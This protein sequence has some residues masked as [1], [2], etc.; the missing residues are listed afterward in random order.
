MP[1]LKT[2]IESLK[3]KTAFSLLKKM[4]EE[5]RLKNSNDYAIQASIEYYLGTCAKFIKEENE[6][7]HFE[8]AYCLMKQSGRVLPEVLEGKIYVCCK[9]NNVQAAQEFANE[10]KTFDS[11]DF[12]G[13]IPDLYLADNLSDACNHLPDFV[14]KKVAV[15][16]LI[17][18]GGGRSQ[19][20]GVDID[21]YTIEKK[22]C[23]TMNNFPVWILDLSVSLTRY[24]Q[25]P[26]KVTSVYQMYTPVA[27]ELFELTDLY[28]C[29]LS[30]NAEITNMLPDTAFIHALMGY[31]KDQD[32][33]WL[34]ILAGEKPTQNAK[35]LY[36][37]GYALALTSA[38]KEEEATNLL[39]GYGEGESASVLAARL[40]TAVAS[41]NIEEY[42]VVF[43]IADEKQYTIPNHL[44]NLFL[45]VSRVVYKDIIDSARKLNIE[46]PLSKRVYQE[47]LNFL[48]KKSVD[49]DFI[50][51]NEH[52]IDKIFYPYVACIYKDLLGL[53]H[54][55]SLL[56]KCVDRKVCDI[57]ARLLI[58]FMN[59]DRKQYAPDLYHLLGE[60][61]ESG[62][63]DISVLSLELE[64][65]EQIED[66]LRCEA[67]TKRLLSLYKDNINV[68]VHR[69]IA[70]N[71]LEGYDEELIE[72]KQRFLDSE[73]ND[74]AVMLVYN[75]Y[76]T[77]NEYEFA[78]ELLYR[79]IL[80]TGSQTLKDFFFSK[81]LLPEVDAIVTK[82]KDIISYGDFVEIA[83]GEHKSHVVVSKGSR[84]DVLVGFNKGA[85]CKIDKN[86]ECEVVIE[87]IHNKYYKLICDYYEDIKKNNSSKYV[88]MFSINDFD[89]EK[90]PLGALM[91]MAGNTPERREQ[92]RRDLQTY[93]SC[94]MPLMSFIN[95]SDIVA[96]TYNKIFG[97]FRVCGHPE[98][99]YQ[100]Q[101]QDI[102]SFLKRDVVLDVTSLLSLHEFDVKYGIQYDGR[103]IVP[104]S[105]VSVLKQELDKEEK[106]SIAFIPESV[107]A[108]L[109]NNITDASKSALWNKIKMLLEWI[110]QRC[111]VKI[112]EEKLRLGEVMNHSRMSNAEVE[113]LV[114]SLK[115]CIL[116]TEDWSYLKSMV[117]IPSMNS[118]CWLSLMGNSHASDWG[119]YML[120]SGNVGYPLSS[121]YLIR[122]YA[123]MS[124]GQPNKY[125]TC[126]EN[127]KYYPKSWENVL[128]A[129]KLLLGKIVTPPL[130]IG[131]TNL[132][133][134]LFNVLNEDACKMIYK[135][136]M[137]ISQD[138]VYKQCVKDA[139]KLSHPLLLT[140]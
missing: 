43:K 47:Y 34:K 124:S 1:E 128:A 13:Y 29:A 96:D 121:D 12:W 63:S 122:E 105:V 20:I 127:L 22:D 109:T 77:K 31:Y 137:V 117:T 133:T 91:K 129:A 139:L 64:M 83:K 50:K 45:A 44:L 108:K 100:N 27:K 18:L 131:V 52:E 57:R 97:D 33:K 72:Y 60:L 118:Y 59:S 80:R 87:S 23:I 21:T 89:F 107:L 92:E 9:N 53:D 84:Y 114:L 36:Y 119:E 8:K 6:K 99:F 90:E 48:E 71:S 14:D 78:T 126:I 61:R 125:S 2:A 26:T 115:G 116:L 120:D 98:Y 15:A 134:Q 102:E 67:I 54:A 17:S 85:S 110:D 55:I 32:N 104:Q 40:Q 74:V 38:G 76:I 28:L 88:K 75:S 106:G 68:V 4:Q 10:L 103:F 73:M 41:D 82:E 30:K 113:S 37:L 58:D 35:E 93:Q 94:N 70:I 79:H 138:S 112:A 42:R 24:I 62:L 136:E 66:Y 140:I 3:V 56:L 51:E 95:D 65:A 11:S 132:L 5:L 46:D 135:R 39:K 25:Y 81:K 111:D 69:L 49:I 7:E 130:V 101:I 86:D 123:K 19:D 16:N